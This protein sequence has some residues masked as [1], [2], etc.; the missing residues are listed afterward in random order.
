MRTRLK[1]ID[2]L[3]NVTVGFPCSLRVAVIVFV[4]V[5]IIVIIFAVALVFLFVVFFLI[6]LLSQQVIR[7]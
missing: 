5:F 6:W 3:K 2:Q 7:S 4:I 1:F